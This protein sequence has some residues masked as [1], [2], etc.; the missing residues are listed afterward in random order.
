MYP[1]N[2]KVFRPTYESNS[3][4]S[5]PVK[6]NPLANF[7]KELQE[8]QTQKNHLAKRISIMQNRLLFAYS[9]PLN[10][11]CLDLMKQDLMLSAQMTAILEK[12]EKKNLLKRS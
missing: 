9:E 8:L 11:Y 5:A 3:N 12:C 4:N 2:R 10:D 7:P 1:N 6:K